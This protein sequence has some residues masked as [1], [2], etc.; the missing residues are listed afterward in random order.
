MTEQRIQ[1]LRRKLQ[2]ARY[3]AVSRNPGFAAPLLAPNLANPMLQELFWE[4]NAQ[5]RQFSFLCGH[6]STIASVL[7]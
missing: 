3:A 1:K 4:M 5:G 7:R 6:D 2:E